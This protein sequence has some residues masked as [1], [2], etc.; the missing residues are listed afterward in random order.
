MYS[1]LLFSTNLNQ[2]LLLRG[3]KDINDLFSYT[4]TEFNTYKYSDSFIK[5]R[6]IRPD[7]RDDQFNVWVQIDHIQK[8]YSEEQFNEAIENL[9]NDLNEYF[10]KH[11]TIGKIPQN[12]HVF[13]NRDFFTKFNDDNKDFYAL[14]VSNPNFI[15]TWEN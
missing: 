8:T 4:Y 9:K 10:R 7:T 1:T 14:Q 12:P 3:K 11:P 15:G 6:E 5:V 2:E 13:V